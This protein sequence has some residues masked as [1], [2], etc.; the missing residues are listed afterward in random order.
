MAELTKGGG[1]TALSNTAEAAAFNAATGVTGASAVAGTG[2]Q[3]DPLAVPLTVDSTGAATAVW[4]VEASDGTSSYA[5]GV[6]ISFSN[7]AAATATPAVALSVAP[8]GQATTG[9]SI[10]A[11]QIPSFTTAG[12][13]TPLFAITAC[14]TTLLF[15]YVTNYP[16]SATSHWETGISIANTGA[17]PWNTIP[18]QSASST[19]TCTLDFQGSG[20]P[21]LI[22]TPA[23]PPAASMRSPS[24]T[25]CRSGFR[26]YLVSPGISWRYATSSLRMASRSFCRTAPSA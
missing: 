21:P 7:S 14:Q 9:S 2:H 19:T 20:A 4:E 18:V 6:Y 23:I 17:D 3:T 12:T 22:S 15:P 5:F 13:A 1:T 8:V 16:T 26:R 11:V 25:L 24:A 10:P